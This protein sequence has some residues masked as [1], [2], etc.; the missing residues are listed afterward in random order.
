[1]QRAIKPLV[2]LLCL[3]PAVALFIAAL[4]NQ[5][6]PDPAEALLLETGEFALRFLIVTLMMSPLRSWR[7]WSW[8]LRYRRMFGLFCYFYACLHLLLFLQFH[9]GWEGARVL[10]ELLERP[11]ITMGFGAWLLM[12]PLALT[13]TRAMQRRLGRNW[14]RL[15]RLVYPALMLGCLHLVWQSRSDIGEALV[16]SV[17]AAILLGFRLVPAL[18]QRKAAA[19]G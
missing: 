19:Q 3:A 14:R 16:Y 13:S 17:I 9:L 2:F 4:Q 5:L 6:G 18:R 1:M 15:H 11:Y 12:L 10:E 8:P 7:G